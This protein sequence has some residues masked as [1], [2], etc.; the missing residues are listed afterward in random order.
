MPRFF[1]EVAYKGTAYSGF[2]KQENAV[3]VQSEVENALLVLYKQN[4][5]LTTSSRTDAGVH[6]LQN[7]FHFD[8]N[9]VVD[10]RRTVYQLNAILSKDIVIKN[11]IQMAEEAHSRFDALSRSYEYRIHQ[12]KN[13][14]LIDRSFYFP[15]QLN[16]DALNEA[17][18]LLSSYQDFTSFSKRNTQV[19][20]FLCDIQN[21]KWKWV[22][23][24]LIFFVSANR[25]LRGM[26]RGLTGTMLKVGRGV[27]SVN[28]FAKIIEARDC[29]KADFSV[30]PQGLFLVQVSYPESIWKQREEN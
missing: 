12:K 6:A 29:R 4:I 1:L 22:N 11:I 27:L 15:Y 26:V 23:N 13:P 5:E 19:K 7:F 30:P 9:I 3:T 16:I 20:T 10:E 17:A 8:A 25:F 14:F 2:Q 28:D 24:E 21:A 18:S